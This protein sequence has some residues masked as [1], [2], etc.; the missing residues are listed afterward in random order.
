MDVMLDNMLLSLMCSSLSR[1][2]C[3]TDNDTLSSSVNVS[4]WLKS[5]FFDSVS[6][7]NTDLGIEGKSFNISL[8]GCSFNMV[9]TF[10]TETELSRHCEHRSSRPLIGWF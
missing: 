6:H 8:D 2:L 5:M 1:T 3:E 9:Q 7:L 4:E 10:S